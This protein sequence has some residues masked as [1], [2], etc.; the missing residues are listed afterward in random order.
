MLKKLLV[1]CALLSWPSL[2]RGVPAVT[3]EG[4]PDFQCGLVDL[5]LDIEI[6]AFA[7]SILKRRVDFH[8]NLGVASLKGGG[9]RF[10]K[11]QRG[12]NFKA[13]VGSQGAVPIARVIHHLLGSPIDLKLTMRV[14]NQSECGRRASIP[15]FYEEVQSGAVRRPGERFLVGGEV[16]TQFG[17]RNLHGPHGGVG[18]SL[19]LVRAPLRMLSSSLG[20]LGSE[21]RS[22]KRRSADQ[23]A[24]YAK[25]HRVIGGP[26]GGVGGL[27]LGA[28]IGATVLLSLGAWW[29]ILLGIN[30]ALGSRRDAIKGV[31]YS[32]AAVA[33]FLLGIV[34]W[35]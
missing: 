13:S 22:G 12:L 20:I 7:K 23:Y 29:I 33:L 35:W 27:P 10:G 8:D 26:V 15:Q 25:Q 32:L 19:G 4:F 5:V 2:A 9:L 11:F 24:E 21:E 28:K 16:G 6:P 17:M 14:H 34:P 18:R 30:L 3:G 1:A 31:G